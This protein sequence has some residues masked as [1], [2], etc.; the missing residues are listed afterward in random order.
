MNK[1]RACVASIIFIIA[2]FQT[3]AQEGEKVFRFL[4][5]PSSVRANALGGNNISV[6]ENDISLVFLNPAALGRE[7]N[8]KTNLNLKC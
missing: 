1:I 3:S 7:M 4:E 5:L 8:I 2:I 6:I